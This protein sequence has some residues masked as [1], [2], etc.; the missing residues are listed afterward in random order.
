LFQRVKKFLKEDIWK[1]QWET[2]SGI[3]KFG[4]KYLKIL[5]FSFQKLFRDQLVL[6]APAL[7]FYSLLSVVPL[8]ALAFG[9]AKGFGLQDVLQRQIQVQLSLPGDVETM[10]L[11]FAQTTLQKA[12][13]GL[14]AGLGLVFLFVAVTL[15][16]SNI[17]LSFNKIW[18][19][20]KGRTLSVKIKDYFS[21]IFVGTILLL[22]SLSL[23]VAIANTSSVFGY[24]NKVITFLLNLIPYVIIWFLFAFFI[25]FM[26]NR[27]VSLKAGLVAGIISGTLYQLFF[28]FYIRLQVMVSVY[29]AIYGS[30]AALPLFLIWLQFS[31]ISLLFGAE[32]SYAYE[33]VKTIDFR[34]ALAPINIRAKKMILLRI[35]H[36]IV[37]NFKD[38]AASPP[39]AYMIANELGISGQLVNHLLE[40]LVNNGLITETIHKKHEEIGYQPGLSPEALTVHKILKTMEEKG[41]TDIPIKDDSE[42]QNI[43]KILKEYDKILE[44]SSLNKKIEQLDT[45]DGKKS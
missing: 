35:V 11:E 31:W 42:F 19:I 5:L 33:N 30:L 28:N 41:M 24:L 21:M 36:F 39:S 8:M 14:V 18:G 15:V 45:I 43:K 26:P 1:I 27:R 2:L 6:R 9:V 38:P 34:H 16:L 23:T 29:N 44:K 25:M 4:V 22:I 10:I 37:K 40:E 3:K 17:E 12:K 20:K 13:G 7:A 32:I